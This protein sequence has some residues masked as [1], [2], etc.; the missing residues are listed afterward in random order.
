MYRGTP[1]L[2]QYGG[3]YMGYVPNG[4]RLLGALLGYGVRLRTR[5]CGFD[6]R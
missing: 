4:Y 2:G 3:V 5:M 6:S 1:L